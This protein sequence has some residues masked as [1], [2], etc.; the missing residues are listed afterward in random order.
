M[1]TLFSHFPDEKRKVMEEI[2]HVVGCGKGS[3]FTVVGISSF[4]TWQPRVDIMKWPAGCF[5]RTFAMFT[6]RMLWKTP[7]EEEEGKR[8]KKRR[9]KRETVRET[10][11][12]QM[13]TKLE[14]MKTSK[15]TV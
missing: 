8:E 1:Q 6:N 7:E 15:M 2:F 9:R 13:R 14:K 3:L 10:E 11:V 12:L 5:P 4:M